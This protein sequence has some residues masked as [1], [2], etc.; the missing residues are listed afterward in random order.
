MNATNHTTKV[1]AQQRSEPRLSRRALLAVLDDRKTVLAL[2]QRRPYTMVSIVSWYSDTQYNGIGF[3]KVCYPDRW[4][5]EQGADIAVRRA[6]IDIL[7]Q[8]RWDEDTARLSELVELMNMLEK[9]DERVIDEIGCWCP[10]DK[11]E[12]VLDEIPY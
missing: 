4:D 12:L 5:D 6:L 2:I 8:V 10:D 3:S 7:H 1:A 9:D 11:I